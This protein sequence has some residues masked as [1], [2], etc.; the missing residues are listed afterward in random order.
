MD[1][2]QKETSEVIRNLINYLGIPGQ[3]IT[4][5]NVNSKI[6][7]LENYDG[8]EKL[9]RYIEIRKEETSVELRLSDNAKLC[10]E[11][12]QEIENEREKDLNLKLEELDI[13]ARDNPDIKEQI[14]MLKIKSEEY[15]SHKSLNINNITMRITNRVHLEHE[16]T[17]IKND[18]PDNKSD[19]PDEAIET[20]KFIEENLIL[21]LKESYSNLKFIS[22]NHNL[23]EDE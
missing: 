8:I 5:I 9:K 16:I 18:L 20:L 21:T 13:L 2:E 17:K 6:Q 19:I 4:E 1:L 10:A 3:T 11:R 14:K 7:D 23:D 15:T 12:I 22:T